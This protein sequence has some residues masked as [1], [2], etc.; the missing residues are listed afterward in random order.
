MHK[1]LY[2]L[3]VACVVIG[4][5]DASTAIQGSRREVEAGIL[6]LL[7]PLFAVA[8][9]AVGRATTRACPQCAERVKRQARRCRHCGAEIA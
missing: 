3:A 7:A 1:L 6:L 8:G 9:F 2:G 5:Y 4:L